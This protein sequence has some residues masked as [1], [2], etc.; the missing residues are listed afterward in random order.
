MRRCGVELQHCGADLGLRFVGLEPFL[1]CPAC[2]FA[3]PLPALDDVA[4][5]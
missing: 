1:F 4:F 2:G 3:V 5:A